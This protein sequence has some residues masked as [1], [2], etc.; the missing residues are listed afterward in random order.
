MDLNLHNGAGTLQ[1]SDLVFAVDYKPTLIHQVVNA[2]MAAARSG[3]KAQKN[4]SAVQGG[5]AKPYRQKGT[6]RARAGT[7]RGPIWRSGGRA[8]AAMPRNYAQ[9]VNRKMYRGALRS[10]LSELIRDERLVVVPALSLTAP[11]TRELAALLE[12]MGL[13]DV[14]IVTETLEENLILAGRNL[15]N[16]DVLAQDELDPVSLVAFDKVLITEGA[17][18]QLEDRL[19]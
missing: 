14:L 6:G 15:P 16:V 9:K 8:F 17:V 5:N 7:T 13:R 11:K 3:T 2:Y 4:R 1:V 12:T 10:I 19:G 18:K